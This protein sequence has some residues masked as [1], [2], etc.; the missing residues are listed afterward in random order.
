M[1]YDNKQEQ[2][3]KQDL[4]GTKDKHIQLF[5]TQSSDRDRCHLMMGIK[6]STDMQ[7]VGNNQKRQGGRQG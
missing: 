1:S 4:Q 3:V 5:I 7:H 6:G 2:R